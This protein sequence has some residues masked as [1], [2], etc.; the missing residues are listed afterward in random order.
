MLARSGPLFTF[1]PISATLAAYSSE[2]EGGTVPHRS[3]RPPVAV[4]AEATRARSW[5]ETNPKGVALL[6]VAG[7][8][9]ALLSL[10]FVFV[11]AT[12]DTAKA[13]TVCDKYASTSGSDGA[14]GTSSSPYR[15]AQKLVDS[16]ASGQVGCL[17]S[18]TYAEGLNLFVSK[19]NIVLTSA[20][21]QQATIKSRIYVREGSNR[22]TVS[23]LKLQGFPGK[24]NVFIRG[25]Y[26]RWLN[27]DVTNGHGHSSCFLL[28]GDADG[29]GLAIGTEIR[30]NSIH[31]CGRM[32]RA[33]HDHGIY[34]DSAR[35]TKIVDNRI[36][37][38]AD[39]GVQLYPNAQETLV[40][41]N[42]INNN[43]QGMVIDGT[44]SNNV[45][46]GNVFSNPMGARLAGAYNVYS[47]RTTRGSGNVVERNCLWKQ[48]GG[49]GI[50][51]NS[52]VFTVRNN[53]VAIPDSS[54]CRSVL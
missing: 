30:S 13:A 8:L 21:N 15:T 41:G 48:G 11:P 23:N 42:T 26:S 53:I 27:N 5:P 14:N 12:Q 9:A 54:R 40:E 19:A 28:A 33:N 6:A 35:D 24:A 22:V 25:D 44:S 17:R 29:Q 43:G 49:S 18:G 16:L 36:Y 45:V 4:V 38:N 1:A 52:S 37:G 46:R 31:D 3:I 50:G 2:G 51:Y 7:L 20:P 47:L 32:P 34:V 39:R 10:M